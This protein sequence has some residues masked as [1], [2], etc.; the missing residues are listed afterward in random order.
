M[1]SG[2]W[3]TGGREAGGWKPAA[4][5]RDA[6]VR[7]MN[8]TRLWGVERRRFLQ[9]LLGLLGGALPGIGG[10]RRRRSGRVFPREAAFY[11]RVDRH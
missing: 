6:E 10:G 5:W 8:R 9:G 1:R 7:V 11:R 4:R 2:E 3:E